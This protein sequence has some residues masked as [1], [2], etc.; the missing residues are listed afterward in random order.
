ML[1]VSNGKKT[2]IKDCNTD[3]E[4]QFCFFIENPGFIPFD[5]SCDIKSVEATYIPDYGDGT[6]GVVEPEKEFCH[7]FGK[8]Q[9][10][11]SVT[12][13]PGIKGGESPA[14]LFLRFI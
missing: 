1:S 7:S 10:K 11:I 13:I 14:P 6:T 9:F 5:K 8:G 12:S 3:K 2:K 4:L